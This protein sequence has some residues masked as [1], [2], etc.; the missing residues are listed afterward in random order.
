M[1]LHPCVL[2]HWQL[3]VLRLPPRQQAMP[4]SRQQRRQPR[5]LPS[6]LPRWQLLEVVVG[7]VACAGVLLAQVLVAVVTVPPVCAATLRQWDANVFR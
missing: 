1:R 6:V 5:Q 2:P 3:L 4:S 7:G